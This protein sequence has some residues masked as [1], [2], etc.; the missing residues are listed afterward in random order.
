M[1]GHALNNLLTSIFPKH[2]LLH[3]LNLFNVAPWCCVIAPKK[4]V[5]FAASVASAT[6]ESRIYSSSS[7]SKVLSNEIQCDAQELIRKDFRL[8]RMVRGMDANV[9][10][11]A[12]A[13]ADAVWVPGVLPVVDD[14][15]GEL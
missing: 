5:Q 4:P 11:D 15:A 6:G 12:D 14:A 9:D 10:M 8:G 13:D 1:F 2:H 7:P 3:N